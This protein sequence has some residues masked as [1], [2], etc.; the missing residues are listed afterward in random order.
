MGYIDDIRRFVPRCEQEGA[1]QDVILEGIRLFPHDILTR[2]NRF[3]HMTSSG[4]VLNRRLDRVLLAYH[5]IY[6]TWAW[7]G[8][9]ADG[10][11]DLLGVA[12][13]EAAEET[14]ITSARP[15][16]GDIAA[17]DVL[18]VCPHVKKGKFV[19]GHQHFN[20]SYILIADEGDA[21]SAKADENS[22][23]RWFDVGEIPRVVGEPYMVGVYQ[24][25]ITTARQGQ[26]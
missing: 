14:G 25:I 15:L 8:G 26:Q 10:D 22:G 1:D 4:L 7:T 12:L 23:V 3:F 21:L 13:R 5:N 18:P 11:G 20:V 16:C 9:H 2:E 19:S 24:R 6:G 17:I